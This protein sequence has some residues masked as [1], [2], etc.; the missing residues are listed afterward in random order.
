MLEVHFPSDNYVNPSDSGRYV[1]SNEVP[2]YL[3]RPES[4]KFWKPSPVSPTA[5]S[6][7][8]RRTT[9]RTT[10]PMWFDKFKNS[11]G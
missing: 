1:V 3:Q 10:S 8:A 5:P 9:R 2:Y 4:E 6:N 7:K 11:K